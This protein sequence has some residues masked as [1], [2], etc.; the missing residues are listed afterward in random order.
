MEGLEIRI[1]LDVFHHFNR[2]SL[3][4]MYSEKKKCV[5]RVFSHSFRCFNNWFTHPH[6]AATQWIW[7]SVPGSVNKNPCLQLLPGSQMFESLEM[8]L[9]QEACWCV[10][11]CCM[12]WLQCFTGAG[13]AKDENL[14]TPQ[15]GNCIAGEKKN[16]TGAS[17]EFCSSNWERW[18]Y[19][20]FWSFAIVWQHGLSWLLAEVKE[21]YGH[22]V[23]WWSEMGSTAKINLAWF[24]NKR[25]IA[26]T[27]TLIC[28]CDDP[29]SDPL[30]YY[31]EL[32][33]LSI[34]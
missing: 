33:Q 29:S 15:T 21:I 3:L 18:C 34:E 19:D 1:P 23:V 28:C 14:E 20:D 10:E 7:R 24:S 8:A 22:S 30:W 32:P 17:D 13:E 4:C 25:H 12:N 26:F 16:K 31:D 9:P 6:I 2:N 5:S 11:I 27:V